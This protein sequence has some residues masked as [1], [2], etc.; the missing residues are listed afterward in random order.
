MTPGPNLIYRCSA[1]LGLFS[2]STIASGNT[3]GAKIRSDG[4]MDAPMLPSTPP[5]VSCPHC[6]SPFCLIGAKPEDEY[7]P[8]DL[9]VRPSISNK[10]KNGGPSIAEADDHAPNGKYEHVHSYETATLEQCLGFINDRTL[11]K[12]T[13]MVLRWYAWH[14]I[15]DRRMMAEPA[16]LN[17]HETQNLQAL[18]AHLDPDNQNLAL[19]RGEVLREL[20]HFDEAAAALDHEFDSDVW[21]KAEQLMRAIER[22]DTSPFMFAEAERDG[23]NEYSWAWIARRHRPELPEQP[24]RPLD[25]PIFHIG[26]RDWWVKVL[27]MLSHNWALLET[28]DDGKTTVYFFHDQGANLSQSPYSYKQTIGRSAVVDSLEFDSEF[29]AHLALERNG[30]ERMLSNPGPWIGMEPKGHFYDARDT[31]EGVYSKQGYWES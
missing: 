19:T 25:P 9:I 18:L 7:D 28:S 22:Q 12:D 3:F 31:E 6:G 24:E 21:P 4:K 10:T 26:N 30:F 1:C 5:L 27:G 8:F 14:L 16:Q 11:T 29:S 17:E 2:R 23:S 13:E 20:G 15:N